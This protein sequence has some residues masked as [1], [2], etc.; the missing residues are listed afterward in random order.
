MN[1]IHVS[2][3]SSLYDRIARI[4]NIGIVAHIDAG[5]TTLTERLLH[6]AGL[7]RRVGT[8]ERG[9]TV[10]D[11]LPQERE[12]G[13]TI[14]AA[15]C[16]LP[17]TRNNVRHIVNLVD[18]PGHVDFGVEVE[19]A[20]RVMDGAIAVID[21]TAGVQAQTMTVWAQADRHRVNRLL[22]INKLDRMGADY[23]AVLRDIQI[24]L[25]V[26]TL[27]LNVPVFQGDAFLGIY[28]QVLGKL[29]TFSPDSTIS[30]HDYGLDRTPFM[31]AIAELDQPFLESYLEDQ[32]PTPDM[33]R[34]AIRRIAIAGLAVPCLAGS[35]FRGI[36]VSSVLDAT[37]DYL[38]SPEIT[39]IGLKMVQA[40]AFKV[41]CDEQRGPL[42]HVRVYSGSIS[43]P[44]LLL[45]VSRGGRKE[46]I[47]RVLQATGG[48]LHEIDSVG[49]GHIA[50]LLGCKG[51]A[52]GDTLAGSVDT[53]QL[54]TI[55]IPPPVLQLALSLQSQSEEDL[56]MA[57]LHSLTLED[58]SLRAG[59]DPNNG[60]LVLSGMGELH[61][62]VATQRLRKEYKCGRVRVGPVKI[63]YREAL[64]TLLSGELQYNRQ[65]G[66]TDR[67]SGLVA[68][69]IEPLPVIDS[70]Y[71]PTAV[72]VSF[73]PDALRVPRSINPE[74]YLQAVRDGIDT[75]LANGPIQGSRIVGLSIRVG[76]VHWTDG[77]STPTAIR[78]CTIQLLEGLC[79][80][81]LNKFHVIEPIM[82]LQVRVNRQFLGSLL[83]DLHGTRRATV[84]S[85]DPIPDDP[86]TVLIEAEAPLASLMGYVTW[87]RSATSGNG[88]MSMQFHGYRPKT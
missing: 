82:K 32:N 60:Q 31:E 59:R 54:P 74:D 20:L 75:G 42:V 23:A 43:A 35:A 78:H 12:R 85:Y 52:T 37:V 34:A 38:P 76:K 18:T 61:L 45:N 36:G 15:A 5:K 69:S 21:G 63:S 8:V 66:P 28:D 24:R 56:L 19:R 80:A 13:I 68:L 53:D 33:I 40:L 79:R 2:H 71:S 27:Q 7:I 16:T 51:T 87:L 10:T 26:A 46:R 50:V 44:T 58:P 14:K 11:Y 86:D 1:I 62:E 84:H 65:L 67:L 72:Q 39:A 73:A 4:R 6:A 48:E 3:F 57:S 77:D 81:N 25:R 29:M 83:P 47:T 70:L 17:W 22:F 64:C 55:T 30:L 49:P 41:V 9:D 88:V